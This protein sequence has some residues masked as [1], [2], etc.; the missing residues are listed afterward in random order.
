MKFFAAMLLMGFEIYWLGE[1]LDFYWYT[2]SLA[3]LWL[4]LGWGVLMAITTLI[5]H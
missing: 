5:I 4:P 1:G 2:G 3:M